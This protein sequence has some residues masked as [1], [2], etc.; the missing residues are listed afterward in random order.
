MCVATAVRVARTTVLALGIAAL[1]TPAMAQVVPEDQQT[2]EASLDLP[3]NLQIFGH[4]NP[5]IRK[6]TAIVN[7][8]V[9]TG[10]DVDQ[11]VALAIALNNYQLR[12]EDVDRLRLQVLR[13]II[14]ETL[15]IQ[16]AAVE[17]ITI[18]K[19]EIDK[20]Y[21][22][23][24]RNYHKSPEEFRTW[25]KQI[26]S[27]ERTIRRQIEGELAWGRLIRRRVDISISDSEIDAVLARILASKG[28]PEYHLY[29]IFMYASPDRAQEV[30]AAE[31]RAIEQLRQG[32]PFQALASQISEASTRAV[33]GD[34]GW[35][36]LPTLQSPQ[37]EAAVQQMHVGQ[38][39][40]PIEL[41]AGFS[42]IYLAD[43]RAVL[44]ADARD[45]KLNLKQLTISFPKGATQQQATSIA[46]DFAKATSTMQGCGDAA[47]VAAATG[48]AMVDN[49]T[50][51]IKDLPAQLQQMMLA[52]QVGQATQPFGTVEDGVRVLVLCGRDD[53]TAEVSL[54]SRDEIEGQLTDQ[55]TSLRA[56]R[57]LRDLRRDALVEYR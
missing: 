54:P 23:V 34:L 6:P 38:I 21:A 30:I 37:L 18:S 35:V 44:T 2:P 29:E 22:T 16:A 49:D 19:D 32:T 33:G 50:M 5:N 26:G 25:L 55:R 46:A 24:T 12:P 9:I 1:S 13:S 28:Q 4:A 36:R 43:Q 56:N 31:Q 40:G 7:D 42:I 15:E 52:L 48:A 53:P 10:T 11:R 14:D 3:A 20:A 39:A 45:A 47:R 57:M 51:R 17:K 41:P 27:S 8:T